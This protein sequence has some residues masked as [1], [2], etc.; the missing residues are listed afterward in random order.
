MVEEIREAELEME[1]SI[2]EI[3]HGEIVG[4]D[5]DWRSEEDLM[6]HMKDLE[7]EGDVMTKAS[8]ETTRSY[9]FK[10]DSLCMIAGIARE[11]KP[12]EDVSRVDEDLEVKGDKE[13]FLEEE[14]FDQMQQEES[15]DELLNERRQSFKAIIEME[16][17]DLILMKNE[18]ILSQKGNKMSLINVIDEKQYRRILMKMMRQI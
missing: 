6:N 7:Q 18:G 9:A 10:T 1:F 12:F 14:E 16:D 17:Q 5:E 8:S 4:E 13:N 15:M 11:K 3:E 2:C